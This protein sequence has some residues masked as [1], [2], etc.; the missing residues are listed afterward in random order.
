MV[1]SKFIETFE[2]SQGSYLA[3]Q[4][5]SWRVQA[6]AVNPGV[7]RPFNTYNVT[8]QPFDDPDD[9]GVFK[10]ST[11]S[12]SANEKN[13]SQE[14]IEKLKSNWNS[15][16]TIEIHARSLANFYGQYA[17]R[18]INLKFMRRVSEREHAILR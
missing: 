3:E 11:K 9:P 13:E 15:T 7:N 8:E 4:L 10:C 18:L 2:S 5:F 12:P 14:L 16:I 17:D 1:S 6:N